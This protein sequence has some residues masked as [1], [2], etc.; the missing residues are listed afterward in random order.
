MVGEGLARGACDEVVAA[1]GGADD[2]AHAAEGVALPG[3]DEEAAR[4]EVR[5]GA[6]RV[7]GQV[8]EVPHP[9]RVEAQTADGTGDERG[10]AAA[11]PHEGVDPAE[12]LGGRVEHGGV[13]GAAGV[14]RDRAHVERRA[15]GVGVA[16]GRRRGR[17]ALE[18]VG[19]RSGVE[20]GGPSRADERRRRAPERVGG[21]VGRRRVVRDAAGDPSRHVQGERGG[22][23]EKLTVSA[24]VPSFKVSD[25]VPTRKVAGI[26]SAPR[27]GAAPEALSVTAPEPA[28]S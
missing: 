1:D 20:G 5:R 8:E 15:S 28:S 12:R 27:N 18:G 24:T 9:E 17:H 21:P 10:V 23:L 4:R 13:S 6:V 11:E 22:Q 7:A 25:A 3:G 26:V 14:R 16:E 2:R 19:R